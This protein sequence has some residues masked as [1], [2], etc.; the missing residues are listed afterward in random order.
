MSVPKIEISLE[1]LQEIYS[2]SLSLVAAIDGDNDFIARE[3][4][5]VIREWTRSR[6]SH[7]GEDPLPKPF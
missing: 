6:L 5:I 7:A 3:H 1:E 2:Q 4:A